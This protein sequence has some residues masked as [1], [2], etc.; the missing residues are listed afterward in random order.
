MFHVW[1][2]FVIQKVWSKKPTRFVIDN[3]CNIRRIISHSPFHVTM[4]AVQMPNSGKNRI[5][6]LLAPI[7]EKSATQG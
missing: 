7:R 1:L 3:E 2:L 5:L 6:T 4:V